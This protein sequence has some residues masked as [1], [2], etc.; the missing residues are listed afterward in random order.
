MP[1]GVD[2]SEEVTFELGLKGISIGPRE[3]R[4]GQGIAA[5]GPVGGEWAELRL[6][7]G[8]ACPCHQPVAGNPGGSWQNSVP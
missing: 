8:V 6:G 7:L 4:R 3:V 5:K 2:V 1:R